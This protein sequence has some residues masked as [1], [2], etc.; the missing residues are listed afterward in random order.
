M[1]HAIAFTIAYKGIWPRLSNEPLPL[2][3]GLLLALVLVPVSIASFHIFELRAE[4]L[5]T[6]RAAFLAKTSIEVA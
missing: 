4:N 2:F 6:G 3:A 5:I 1:L